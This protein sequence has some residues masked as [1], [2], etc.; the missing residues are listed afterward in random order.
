M[1]ILN[2]IQLI[3]FI[4]GLTQGLI[5]SILLIYLDQRKNRPTLLLG[6]FIFAYSIN[7]IEPIS[8]LLKLDENYP[9]LN[10]LPLDFSWLLF[11]LFYV[12]IRNLS[13]LPKSNKIYIYLVPGMVI[14]IMNMLVYLK[15]SSYIEKLRFSEVFRFVHHIGGHLY[16]IFIYY[17]TH[18]FISKHTLE[19]NN[20]Y[21]STTGRELKWAKYFMLTGVLFTL[22]I[23]FTSKLHNI[24]LDL[25][26][27]II[28]VGLLY[29]ISIYGIRQ[30]TIK[31]LIQQK[32]F[33]I[34]KNDKLHK[35][36]E[37]SEEDKDL[38]NRVQ[39]IFISQKVYKN[40]DLAIV[41]IANIIN[42]HPKKISTIINEVSNK[43]FKT[44]VNGFR[45]NEAK[46]ILKSSSSD[47][48]SIEGIILEV[49]FKS[50]SAFYDAFRKETGTTPINYQNKSS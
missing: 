29:W 10:N 14:L 38:F 43:N 9:F 25:T 6:L 37:I 27:A 34:E 26:E 2:N 50:K 20:Q 44:F 7:Y 4:I 23:H 16:A 31:N 15:V 21:A 18:K 45:I 48:Y 35:K 30:Q 28:N 17:Q 5:F 24:Y 40:P 39:Q 12:Y 22:T 47:Y 1:D 41:D 3:I 36:N 11:A 33:V 46:E 13:L 8:A 49:G 19:I 42:E 32:S